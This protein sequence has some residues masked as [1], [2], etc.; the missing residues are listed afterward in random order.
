MVKLNQ[1][2]LVYKNGNPVTNL[3]CQK[4]FEKQKITR[5]QSGKIRYIKGVFLISLMQ[6]SIY[7]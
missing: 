2:I 5:N 3:E 1:E 6:M 4:N 7:L